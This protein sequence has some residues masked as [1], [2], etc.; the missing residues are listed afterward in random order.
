MP[1]DF[2]IPLEN[3]PGELAKVGKA[4]GEAGLNVLGFCA[5]TSG[6]EGTVH[7]LVDDPDAARKALDS[8]DI[9][10]YSEREMA[11]LD[12]EDAPGTLGEI[13]AQIASRGGNIE[14]GYTVV[15]GARLAIGADDPSAVAAKF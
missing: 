7:V 5:T 1:T 11:V 6:D 10:T 4:F 3:R 13:A 12:V 14:L 9:A 8:L 15:G 2:A